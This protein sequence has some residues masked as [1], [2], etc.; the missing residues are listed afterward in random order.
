MPQKFSSHIGKFFFVLSTM[1]T[2]L[3]SLLEG[4]HGKMLPHQSSNKKILADIEVNWRIADYLAFIRKFHSH[5]GPQGLHQN[6]EIEIVMDPARI[7]EIEE[8]EKETLLHRGATEKEAEEWSRVGVIYTDTY[9]IWIR[10]AVIY[11]SGKTGTYDRLIYKNSI[12]GPSGVAVLPCLKDG[13]IILELVYRHATRAWEVELARGS[14]D[15]GESPLKAAYRELKE[16]TGFYTD[17]MTYLGSVTADTTTLNTVIP[18]YLAPISGQVFENAERDLLAFTVEE[19]R[20][21]LFRGYVEVDFQ[22]EIRKVPFRDPLVSFALLQASVRN[23]IPLYPH[24]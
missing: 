14:R 6:H 7:R 13:R 15:Y 18:V 2:S 19:I 11:P 17:Q 16:K 24:N 22:G 21:A 4:G 23:L 1:S 5:L 8:L 20:D 9:W 10:D 3:F 12:D